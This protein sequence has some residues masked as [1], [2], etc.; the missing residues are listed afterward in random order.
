MVRIERRWPMRSRIRPKKLSDTSVPAAA[1]MRPKPSVPLFNL[2]HP[3]QV[4]QSWR[5]A[6]HAERINEKTAIH[7]LL[8]SEIKT[9]SHG[10]M[11]LGGWHPRFA[12]SNARGSAARTQ[13]TGLRL[14]HGSGPNTSAGGAW[15]SYQPL[16]AEALA[17]ETSPGFKSVC[18]SLQVHSC[19]PLCWQCAGPPRAPELGVRV[20]SIALIKSEHFALRMSVSSGG[21]HN[22]LYN[23]RRPWGHGRYTGIRLGE[24]S[25]EH[26]VSWGDLRFSQLS[27]LNYQL[28]PRCRHGPQI[29]RRVKI[30][31]IRSGS[32]RR[33]GYRRTINLS[34]CFPEFLRRA[35]RRRHLS[36]VVCRAKEDQPST[37]NH[38]PLRPDI[39]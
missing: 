36:A 23:T 21:W 29:G 18:I 6:A 3:P 1:P 4:G 38:Q 17:K 39:S 20:R 14:G 30:L 35:R 31:S 12:Q 13:R 27:S 16:G 34:A 7:S 10:I 11:G 8:R 28:R 25:P 15:K 37:I 24:C 33:S 26:L 2:H 9:D 22:R 19:Q 32:C 5:Q